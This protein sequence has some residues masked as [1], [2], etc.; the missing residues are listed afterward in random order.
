[1]AEMERP[2]WWPEFPDDEGYENV[3]ETAIWQAVEPVLKEL[4]GALRFYALPDNHEGRPF[5]TTVIKSRVK[6]DGGKIAAAVLQRYE[7]GTIG[8]KKETEDK[9]ENQ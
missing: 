6:E 8:T 5:S 7:A 9:D 2:K 3:T 1:M 4:V